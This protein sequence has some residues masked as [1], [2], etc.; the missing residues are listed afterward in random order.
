MFAHSPIP[1]S[2]KKSKRG[3]KKTIST[4]NQFCSD[5]DCAYYLIILR[6]H[7]YT[8]LP[9]S[10]YPNS[11]NTS[12][13]C[14]PI[15]GGGRRYSTGVSLIFNGEPTKGNS[16]IVGCSIFTSISRSFTSGME[17]T[18]SR[19][20]IGPHGISA[21]SKTDNHSLTLRVLKIDLS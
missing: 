5:L 20:L 4:Q 19:L 17:K 2:E 13:V 8:F 21:F 12:C 9:S 3:R 11:L 15:K 7:F 18:C 16:P 1:W 14:S 6:L 10:P